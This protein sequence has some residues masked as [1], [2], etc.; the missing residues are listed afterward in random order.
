MG[1][2]IAWRPGGLGRLK[3]LEGEPSGMIVA[4]L[5]EDFRGGVVSVPVSYQY[6]SCCPS[7]PFS[8]CLTA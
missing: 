1:A 3:G 2:G 8:T 5:I 4:E 6:P 7:L